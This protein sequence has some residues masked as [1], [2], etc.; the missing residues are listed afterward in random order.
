MTTEYSVCPG[1]DGERALQRR[2]GTT[3]RAIRF[4]HKQMLDH[5]NSHM[6][7][8]LRRQEMFFVA[9]ADRNGECDSSFRAGPPGVLFVADER[10]VLYPEYRGNGVF[11]SLG[12]IEENPHVGILVIDFERARI[13]LHINGGAEILESAAAR[14]MWPDLPVEQTPGQRAQVWVKVSVEEA[15]IHC[16]KHIPHM[17]KVSREEA[18][19]WGTDDFR[20]KGGDF[21]HVAEERAKSD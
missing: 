2:L 3:D 6:R 18:R 15:Y 5:L 21:F 16:A 8:Y 17:R 13:G 1:T 12:N 11:A 19:S 14:A 4:H 20:R 9:T 10:T 7:A